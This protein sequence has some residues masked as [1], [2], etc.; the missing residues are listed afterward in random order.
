MGNTEALGNLWLI[1]VRPQEVCFRAEA[2]RPDP[3]LYGRLEARVRDEL[4]LPLV[5][6][7]VAPGG[8]MDR[9]RLLR[10]DPVNKPR[11]VGHVTDPGG[12]ALTLDD[13]MQGGG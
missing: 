11:V 10:I 12:A 6:D 13:L 5:I 2:S 4:G 8:L 7:A 1:E 3:D 9:D